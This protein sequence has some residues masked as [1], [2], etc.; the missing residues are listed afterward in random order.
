MPAFIYTHHLNRFCFH[1]KAR[2]R[3]GL[4]RGALRRLTAAILFYCYYCLL[5]YAVYSDGVECY[6]A[7]L[8]SFDLAGL[9]DLDDALLVHQESELF[10]LLQ[11]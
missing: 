9:A 2:T 8:Q 1:A 7:F 10:A 6:N 4:S 5:P 11:E 3:D